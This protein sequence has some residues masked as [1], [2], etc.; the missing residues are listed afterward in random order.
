MRPQAHIEMTSPPSGEAVLVSNGLEGFWTSYPA[1]FVG[2]LWQTILEC[3][4]PEVRWRAFIHGAA[5]VRNGSNSRFP[6][7]PE[8]ESQ[9][10]QPVSLPGFRLP[11]R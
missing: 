6:A 11:R 5:L 7:L 8:A 9:R 3:I 10:W 1:Q 4:H 2:G